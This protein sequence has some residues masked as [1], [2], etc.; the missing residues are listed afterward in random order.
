M[1]PWVVE[2]EALA[3]AK[4][5]AVRVW[6]RD[7]EDA[8]I[9]VVTDGEQT[10]RHF[11][12]KFIEGL[13]GVDFERGA[14][15][16]DPAAL[17]RVGTASR[18][19]GLPFSSVY[20]DDARFTVSKT[21]RPVKYQLPGPMTMAD[22]LADEHYRDREALAMAFAEILNA[23]AKELAAAGVSVIPVRRAGRGI[24]L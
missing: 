6:L 20:V 16:K 21:L 7:Q 4:R 9:D 8:G 24:L 17:R 11:V 3:E 18:R 5:D 22:T 13:D 14:T 12:T 10:R 15:V 1:A 23:E 19:P 2:G